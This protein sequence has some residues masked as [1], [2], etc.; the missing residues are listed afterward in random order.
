MKKVD[1]LIIGGGFAG[2]SAA[3]KLEKN[4]I[5]TLLVDKKDYFEV[6]F[7]TLRNVAAPDITKNKARKQYKSFLTGS[8]IQSGVTKLKS[9][10]ATL[11][12]GTLVEFKKAIIASGTR[13]P[14]MPI[15]K[16]K[17]ALDLETRNGEMLGYNDELKSADKVLIIGGGVVG[18]ELAG[19]IAYAFP[20][21]KTVLA[22]NTGALLDGFK[23]KTRRIALEQL[24]SLGVEVEFNI[25]YSNVDGAYIDSNTGKTSDADFVFQAVGTLPNS[26]FLQPHLPHILDTKGFVKV[27]DKLEVTGQNNLYA[28][29]D[30]ADVGEPKLGYLAQQQGEYVAK[31]IVKKLKNKKVKGYKRNPLIALIPTG[32][33][34]GVAELPFAV[35][36]FKSLINMKQKDLFIKKVHTAF[37]A[38]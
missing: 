35:T 19:E 32:Q 2:V 11:E 23:E 18:V 13:Y 20:V 29:G 37:G 30:V 1:I 27:N 31:S 6:T 25:S 38:D 9:S 21:K 12:D 8:F 26:E 36:T 22:H 17:T 28:L 5:E 16:S 3:Q 4:G 33:K 14:T 7:A 24:K 15:A 34:S 10:V